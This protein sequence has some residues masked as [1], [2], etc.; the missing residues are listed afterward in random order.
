M[1]K[2]II[3]A[4]VLAI[5]AGATAGTPEIIAYWAQNNN[6]LSGGGF[7]FEVGDFPQSADFGTQAGTAN[8][9]V[10]GGDALANDGTVYTWLQSFGGTTTNAQFGEASGGSIALQNGD[11]GINNGAFFEFN[12]NAGLYENIEFSLARQATATGFT[13]VAVDAFNG[14]TLLGNIGSINTT[15]AS[16]FALYNFSASLLDGVSDA[17]IRLTFTGGSDTSNNGNNRLDNIVVSGTLIPTPGAAA[18]LGLGGLVA[19]R[20]RRA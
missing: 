20:R 15:G 16:S 10:G 7:G 18:L 9:T 1:N 5:A 12:F 3:G 14:D 19:A 17:T 6:S 2:S 13:T 11:G 4:A 8:L